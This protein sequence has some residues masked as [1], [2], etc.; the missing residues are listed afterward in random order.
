MADW[1]REKINPIEFIKEYWP[2]LDI[3]HI[4]YD[5]NFKRTDRKYWIVRGQSHDG[6]Q[7]FTFQLLREVVMPLMTQQSFFKPE[8][9]IDPD[10][11]IGMKYKVGPI[12][13]TTA[14][15]TVDLPCGRY[16]G[17]RERA[18]IAVCSE[19]VYSSDSRGDQ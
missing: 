1:R 18:R 9:S 19:C 11:I 17:Q 6:T 2:E 15:G 13:L 7:M 4:E 3:S 5:P 10:R 14:Y 16:P 8:I 12:L